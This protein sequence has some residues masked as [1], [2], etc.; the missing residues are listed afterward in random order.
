MKKMSIFLI[1]FFLS[2][3]LFA[4]KY[5][6]GLD[7]IKTPTLHKTL[8]EAR[9]A[10]LNKNYKKACELI[11]IALKNKTAPEFLPENNHPE[12]GPLALQLISEKAYY[13]T[14]PAPKN[15]VN[16]ETEKIAIPALKEFSKIAKNKRWAAYTILYHR[17]IVFYIL[18]DEFKNAEVQLDNMFNYD[19]YQI[20]NYL[21]WG[22][23]INL[24]TSKANEKIN[25]HVKQTGSY[26]SEIIFLKIRYKD[27]DGKNVFQDCIDFLDEY[28]LSNIADLMQTVNFLRAS[29]NINNPKQVEKY[30]KTI[31]RL[32]FA[33]PNR[34]D[35]LDFIKEILTEKEKVEMI[36]TNITNELE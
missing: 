22:L 12:I 4:A 23:Q 32:A 3:N 16:P 20:L 6:H 14:L 17:L 27:R 10:Y 1:A 13:K 30:Y 36:H 11:D 25:S 29:L 26:S 35:R 19:P 33:Q 31:N 7:G 8:S 34:Q 21:N 15:N 2:A 24:P 9:S 5:W 28:P 18:K